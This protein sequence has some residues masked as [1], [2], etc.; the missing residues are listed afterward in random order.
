MKGNSIRRLTIA[1][2][3]VAVLIGGIA[4]LSTSTPGDVQAAPQQGKTY[5][6]ENIGQSNTELFHT[7]SAFDTDN[8]DLRFIR[9]NF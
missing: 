5:N 4:V 2:V 8:N 9:T 1:L 3:A 7:A 6:W